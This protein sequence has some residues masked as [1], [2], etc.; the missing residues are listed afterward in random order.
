[1]CVPLTDSQD[2]DLVV[3]NGEGPKRV[4]VK[5]TTASPREGYYQ[6]SLRTKGGNRSGH[7]TKFFDECQVDYLFIVTGDGSMYLVPKEEVKGRSTM[8]LGG[9]TSTPF[10]V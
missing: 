1:M 5:T 7:T 9:K 2:Y 10:R 4:Q 8:G 6:A 3:D